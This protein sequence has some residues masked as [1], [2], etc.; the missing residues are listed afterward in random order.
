M[1][2]D[3]DRLMERVHKL[4]DHFG[5]AQRDIKDVRISADKISSRGTKI[6]ALEL[7]DDD[8]QDEVPEPPDHFSLE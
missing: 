5:L 3:V 7:S 6:E 8:G 1:M 4:E 2:K